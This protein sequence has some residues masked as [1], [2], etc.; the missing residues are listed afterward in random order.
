MISRARFALFAAILTCGFAAAPVS[1]Q[2]VRGQLLDADSGFP[3]PLGLVMMFTEAGDSVT[4]TVADEIGRF[5][6]TSDEPGAFVLLAD[7]LG[8]EETPAGVFELGTDGEMTVEYRLAPRPLPIDEIIV[9]LDRPT[10][11]H[12]LVRNGFVRR[13]Q[14][15]A[16]IHITPHQIEN[17]VVASTEEL[18]RGY[19]GV[20]ISYASSL[21]GA[22]AL[23]DPSM[24][25]VLEIQTTGGWCLPIVYVDG[26]RVSYGGG[27]GF[28]LSTYVNVNDLEAIEVYRRAAEIPVEYAG[29][30]SGCGV[31]LLWSKTGLAPGQRPQGT[32]GT[33]DGTV[34]SGNYIDG[35]EI[36]LLPDVG[37]AGV[38]PTMGETIRMDIALE[39]MVEL[40]LGSPWSGTY[41]ATD[42]LNVIVT[43]PMTARAMGLP[44]EHITRIQVERPRDPSYAWVR[45]ARWSAGAG[46]GTWMSLTFLCSWS[47]CN[48]GALNTWVPTAAVGALVFL[49][50]KNQGAGTHWVETVI[51]VVA[52]G[53]DGSAGLTW[54]VPSGR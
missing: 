21:F 20:R 39:A 14:R 7:A 13:F 36:M 19:P 41:V 52:P 3:V 11:M 17:A 18:L 48:P 46:L 38:P 45:A 9:S 33:V 16:G 12:H 47:D 42:E 30:G 51:P 34:R 53:Q 6:V 26:I 54:R 32:G 31:V 43:D 22:A 23:S 29:V 15:G 10:R 4:A 37:E 40:G 24:G 8:Y 27:A 2:T 35:E 50:V 28:T 1:G 49:G 25:E 5:A 44:K